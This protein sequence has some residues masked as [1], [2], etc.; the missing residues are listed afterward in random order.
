MLLHNI[1]MDGS[2]YSKNLHDSIAKLKSNYILNYIKRFDLT[3]IECM[4]MYKFNRHA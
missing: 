4:K 2:R 3:E 1:Y